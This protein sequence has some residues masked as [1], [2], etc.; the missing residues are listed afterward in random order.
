MLITN[1]MAER[2]RIKRAVNR[3]TMKDLAQKLGTTYKTLSLIEQ[4]D[5]G[6]FVAP[7]DGLMA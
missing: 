7:S 6:G 5:Y 4:G 3:Q 1:D 2:I